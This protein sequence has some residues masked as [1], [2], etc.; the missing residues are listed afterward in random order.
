MTAT[1]AK[2]RRVFRT[3]TD[4]IDFSSHLLKNFKKPNLKIYLMAF[5]RHVK[6]F[7]EKVLEIKNSKG[8]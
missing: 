3:K 8:H 7:L 1:D 4:E 6:K 2:K 5:E